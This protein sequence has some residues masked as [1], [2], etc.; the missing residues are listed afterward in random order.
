MSRA[1]RNQ[2][3][4]RALR[5]SD[6]EVHEIEGV[7]TSVAQWLGFEVTIVTFAGWKT[8]VRATI[9]GVPL[10]RPN[11]KPTD[12]NVERRF[13]TW[14]GALGALRKAIRE[15]AEARRVSY[16]T[17]P[18]R[19]AAYVEDPKA[20][21]VQVPVPGPAPPWKTSRTAHTAWSGNG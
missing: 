20:N 7:R 14:S 15:A 6:F 4:N 5:E 1:V 13:R 21:A 12:L 17:L 3:R 11:A 19:R 16:N 8:A 10:R 18:V 9:N 2:V